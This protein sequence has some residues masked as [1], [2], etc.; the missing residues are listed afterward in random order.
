[1]GKPVI[2]DPERS[3]FE[4][5]RLHNIANMYVNIKEDEGEAVAVAYLVA[6][7]KSFEVSDVEPYVQAVMLERGYNVPPLGE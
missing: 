7:L 4:N 3:Q 1:M 5:I 2:Q 6:Q